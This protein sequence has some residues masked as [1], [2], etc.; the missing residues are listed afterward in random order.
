MSHY[1]DEKGYTNHTGFGGILGQNGERRGFSNAATLIDKYETSAEAIEA[2]G[3]GWTVSKRPL[4]FTGKSNGSKPK[5]VEGSFAVVKDDD[6]QYLGTVGK[7]YHPIANTE[8]F[9]WADQVPGLYVAGGALRNNRQVYLIKQLESKLEIADEH[10]M[11]LMLRSSHDGTKSLQ[12]IATPVRIHCMNMMPIA[13]RSAKF[14]FAV[15]HVTSYNEKLAEAARIHKLVDQYAVEF[16]KTMKVLEDT[17]M[18]L[19]DT[20]ALLK[21][22]MPGR[23]ELQAGVLENLQTSTTIKDD[24]RHTAFGVLNAVTE[25]F[26]WKREVTSPTHALSANVDGQGARIRNAVASRLLERGR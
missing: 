8:A 7:Q 6:E 23:V 16:S 10:E 26:E 20:E 2:A 15:R 25:F 13:L 21:E 19:A 14:K 5:K 4:W 22:V 11:F 12:A 1:T 17:E 24:H 3:L 9:G 18:L